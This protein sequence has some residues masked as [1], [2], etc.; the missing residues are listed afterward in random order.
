MQ[1]IKIVVQRLDQYETIDS[2]E[3]IVNL[4]NKEMAEHEYD[5]LHG[6]VRSLEDG[7]RARV[8]ALANI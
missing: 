7:L 2:I 5:V 3:V 8:A 6:T 4:S 1:K